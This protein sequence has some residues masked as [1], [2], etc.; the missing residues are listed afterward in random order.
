MAARVRFSGALREKGRERGGMRGRE[1]GGRLRGDL[2]LAR[3]RQEVADGGVFVQRV[4]WREEE[5]DRTGVFGKPPEFSRNFTNRSFSKEN[6][7]K[8][9]VFRAFLQT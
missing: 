3:S 9:L 4:Y 8:N 2:I 1:E 7:E 6:S 5:E